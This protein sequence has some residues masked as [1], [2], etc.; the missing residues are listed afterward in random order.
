V[1]EAAS[2]PSRQEPSIFSAPSVPPVKVS[3]ISFGASLPVPAV[4]L[5][6]SDRPRT[7]EIPCWIALAISTHTALPVAPSDRL[8][9]TSGIKPGIEIVTR[10]VPFLLPG[11]K[12]NCVRL[13]SEP[14]YLL[15]S[16]RQT[17]AS[18]RTRG[19]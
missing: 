17:V 5:I 9:K 10:H 19:G 18:S 14:V 12:V 6:R 16:L 4:A 2:E 7:P 11:A 3:V 8:S 15:S 13:P 1:R